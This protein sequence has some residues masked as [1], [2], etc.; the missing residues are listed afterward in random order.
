MYFFEDLKKMK[1]LLTLEKRAKEDA[2]AEARDYKQTLRK[3][4]E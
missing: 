4:E 2:Q 1:D 3:V